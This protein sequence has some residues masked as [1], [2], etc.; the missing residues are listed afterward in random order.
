MKNIQLL[1]KKKLKSSLTVAEKAIMSKPKENRTDEEKQI[2]NKVIGG[3][4]C[5]KRYPAV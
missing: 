4:K 2:L 3:L 1:T 5:F